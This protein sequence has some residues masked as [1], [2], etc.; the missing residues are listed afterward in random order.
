M[1]F[2]ARP[3]DAARAGAFRGTLEQDAR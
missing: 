1:A 2:N 3:G